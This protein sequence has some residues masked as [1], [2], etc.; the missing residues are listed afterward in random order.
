MFVFSGREFYV[1]ELRRHLHVD[2]FGSCGDLRCG[3]THRDVECYSRLLQPT[4]KFYLSFENNMCQDYITEK[5]GGA[6]N[7]S[8]TL[9]IKNYNNG[10]I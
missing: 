1:K 6:E 3:K 9:M 4:Y 5:V 10:T 2:V 8:N 7:S